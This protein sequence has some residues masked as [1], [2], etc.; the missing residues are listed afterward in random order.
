MFDFMRIKF[1]ISLDIAV[2]NKTT[3][4]IMSPIHH[5]RNVDSYIAYR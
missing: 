3:L 1:N 2:F 4:C 5:V